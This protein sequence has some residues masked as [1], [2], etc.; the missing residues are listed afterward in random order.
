MPICMYCSKVLK[1]ERGL[2]QHL[3]NSKCSAVHEQFVTKRVTKAL[4]DGNEALMAVFG[5]DKDDMA[6]PQGYAKRPNE[7]ED[8]QPKKRKAQQC[9]D[10]K[11][12][13]MPRNLLSYKPKALPK[14]LH[15]GQKVGIRDEEVLLA[16]ASSDD[17]QFPLDV[18]SDDDSEETQDEVDVANKPD[19]SSRSNF[20]NYC[21]NAPTKFAAF[22][23]DH[24]AAIQLLDILR[25]KKAPLDT[26]EEVMKWHLRDKKELLDGQNLGECDAYISRKVLLKKLK[27]RYNMHD[28]FPYQKEIVL[29]FSRAKVKVVCMEARDCIESL[30]TDPR[31]KDSDFDFFDNDPFAPPPG[32]LTYV[33]GAQT[34]KAYRKGHAAYVKQKGQMG[35]GVMWYI[36][37]AVT[38]Q[39]ENLE[40]TALKIS[41]TMFTREYRMKDH[42][43]R[44]LGYV[45]NYSKADSRGKKIFADSKHID[46]VAVAANL[47]EKEGEEAAEGEISVEK[48]QDFHAQLNTILQSYLKLQGK[49]MMWDLYYRGKVHKTEL[50]F[51]T[52]MVR[53]DTDEAELLCGKFRMRSGKVQCLC[54][55][56]TCPREDT[57]NP[58]ACYP[59][60]TVPMMK[61]LIE[62][63]DEAGL[64]K[65]SQQ[66]LD[67]CWYQVRFHPGDRGIHGA[68]PAEMLHAMLLGIF[69]YARECFFQ[70]IGPKSRLALEIN[71]LA[72]VYG[73]LSSH[74]SERDMPKCKFSEG[75]RKTGKI[76]AKEYRGVL[77]VMAI[78]LRSTEGQRLLKENRNF[79]DEGMI[80]DWLLLVEV[81][82]QWEVYLCEPQMQLF[83]VRRLMQK[84][85]FIMHILK[86]VAKRSTG[87]GLKLFK[88]HAIVHMALDI[89]LF[90]VPMEHDTGS[91]ESGHKVTKVAAKLTQK[92]ASVFE[93]QTATR[94]AEFFLIELAME[95]LDGR[96]LW[97]YFDGFVHQ[98][99]PDSQPQNNDSQSTAGDS[100]TAISDSRTGGAKIVVYTGNDGAP[101]WDILSRMKDADKSMWNDD[102][103]DCL[104]DLQGYVAH[105]MEEVPLYTEH[106]RNGH[107]FRSHPNYRGEGPWRDWALFDWGE[108]YGT[109]PCEIWG[110]VVLKGLPA[111]GDVQPPLHFAGI[112]IVDGTY[113]LVEASEW[114]S[115]QKAVAY[116]DIFVPFEKEVA[117]I[118]NDGQVIDR[119]FYLADVEAIVKPLF[120]LP[121]IGAKPR[122]KYFQVK[123]RSAWVADFVS[124]LEAPHEEDVLSDSEDEDE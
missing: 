22:D 122:C 12:Q 117:R 113:A 97:D 78:I 32:N 31:L 43:W 109:L 121:D 100:A 49:G 45:V 27:A 110:F 106:K 60:K 4:D 53:C 79:R 42:A 65:I 107:I 11:A 94:L 98:Q 96:P 77:L 123:P 18:E 30:L 116:S 8:C 71:A 119:A 62:E 112:D 68:C 13:L 95:E 93:I 99:E 24:R 10:A 70:Q 39:F 51:W 44:T 104:Y 88:F 86:K 26:Y 118:G 20:R 83:H 114:S 76:M 1:T 74:Q 80:K 111:V 19:D 87:M 48:A 56:C 64:K 61:K 67:N 38:G 41:L 5:L 92:K 102:V 52:I 14:V 23:D 101:K 69:K 85:R 25:R 6:M 16:A 105:W 28:K 124:W 7:E 66:K 73:G 15:P 75:I 90:G 81:L 63:N 82:L 55:Y 120:V 29:P 34:G 84:N 57:D 40:I 35:A 108:D 2:K 103:R 115:D 59:F 72:K 3:D 46:S 54:R 37:G 33:A 91:N 21:A 36:D 89:I 47:K 17:N 9:F 58:K 50:V